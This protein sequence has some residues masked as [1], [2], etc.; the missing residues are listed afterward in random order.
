MSFFAITFEHNQFQLVQYYI[1]KYYTIF[2]MKL[3]TNSRQ[4]WGNLD[5]KI[6]MENFQGEVPDG[7]FQ[8][9]LY[10]NLYQF[11]TTFK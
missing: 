10:E 8:I 4:I 3:S 11:K 6:L 7:H 1:F 9:Y 5:G 2:Y